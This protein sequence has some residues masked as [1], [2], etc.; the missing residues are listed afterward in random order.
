MSTSVKTIAPTGRIGIEMPCVRCG[1]ILKGV[2]IGASCPECGEPVRTT[3]AARTLDNIEY[4][5]GGLE[6]YGLSL[7]WAFIGPVG[8]PMLAVLGPLSAVVLAGAGFVRVSALSRIARSGLANSAA[9]KKLFRI[10]LWT[11]WILAVYGGLVATAVVHD[12]IGRWQPWLSAEAAQVVVLLWI[13]GVTFEIALGGAIL[14]RGAAVVEV[15]W[16]T[17]LGRIA[18][19]LI[20]AGVSMQILLTLLAVTIG[21]SLIFVAQILFAWL[22]IVIGSVMMGSF[23]QKLGGVATELHWLAATG[24]ARPDSA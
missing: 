17:N 4:A 23:V 5:R 19:G 15:G 9:F 16:L 3:L 11:A 10:A 1:Q 6:D 13:V 14:L 18:V 7:K 21:G 8:L 2:G 22:P 12:A 20:V 24:V